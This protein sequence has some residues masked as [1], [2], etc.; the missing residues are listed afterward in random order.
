MSLHGRVQRCDGVSG[1]NRN[2]SRTPM[3][4]TLTAEQSLELYV[5]ITR[6][7]DL[8]SP[9]VVEEDGPDGKRKTV[10]QEPARITA[11]TR[12]N[13]TRTQD[14]VKSSALAFEKARGDIIKRSIRFAPPKDT[15]ENDEQREA[16]EAK[17]DALEKELDELKAT[18]VEY[19]KLLTITEEQYLAEI[20]VLPLPAQALSALL[21]LVDQ[22]AEP[23]AAES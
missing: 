17:L 23:V 6:M 20:A 11:K 19:D 5:G 15:R 22:P 12:Y 21:I 4:K 13:L 2:P 14:F 7:L 1:L 16:R 8:Q 18:P 10:I 3:K 9:R